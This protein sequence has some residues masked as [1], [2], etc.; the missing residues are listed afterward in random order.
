LIF[1][2]N[3]IPI[4]IDEKSEALYRRM[5]IIK[6]D[7]KPIKKNIHLWDSLK[8]EIDYSVMMAC[9]SLKKMYE[10]GRFTES[11]NSKANVEE[12]YME[13]DNI[14]AFIIERTKSIDGKFTKSSTLYDEYKK[15]C[16]DGDRKVVGRSGFHKAMKNKGY[17]K[18]RDFDGEQYLDIVLLEE[19]SLPTDKDGFVSVV[20]ME[21]IDMPFK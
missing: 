6:I 21:Q 18:K 10:T 15:Y 14:M 8:A 19:N 17:I 20:G 4:N 1:S 3:E 7:K 9:N 2:A 13:A 5:L 11:D 16:E 12:L